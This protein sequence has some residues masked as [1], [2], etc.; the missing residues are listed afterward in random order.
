MN[1]KSAINRKKDPDMSLHLQHPVDLSDTKR[2]R[3]NDDDNYRNEVES[4]M[5]NMDP[6]N[7]LNDNK[8]VATYTS[9]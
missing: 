2:A 6:K 8:S 1:V 9:R 4:K 7:I 3:N 5:T